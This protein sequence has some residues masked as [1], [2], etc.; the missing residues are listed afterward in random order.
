MNGIPLSVLATSNSWQAN[1]VSILP[2]IMNHAK[3][4]FRG[5]PAH[6]REDAVAETIAAAC[7]T[8]QKLAA[9]G[10]LN[11][12][13]ISSLAGFSARHAAQH[14]HVGGTQTS[15]DALSPLACRKHGFA[16]R[17]LAGRTDLYDGWKPL[18]VEARRF[19]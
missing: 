1:F 3:C 14:R 2:T 5:L 19:S 10:K 15:S 7:L 11:Q 16:V 18:V 17:N 9:Q 8:Y 4:R 13:Y 12:A 6:R